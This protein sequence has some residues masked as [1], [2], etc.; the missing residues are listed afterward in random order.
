MM[1]VTAEGLALIKTFEGLRLQAYLDSANIPTLGYG[2][3]RYPTGQ[4]VKLGD[5]C[6]EQ[7]AEAYLRHDLRATEDAVDAMTTDDLSPHQF[8]ALVSLTY[9]IGSHH[10][11]HS[12][13]RQL[14]NA[15]P[16]S[17]AIRDQFLRWVYAGGKVVRGLRE[18]RKREAEHYFS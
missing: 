16:D 13:L 8:D 1:R 11:R 18:R 15:M 17:P 7:Q 2:T 5:T 3:I 6:T 9:N 4:R 14:V 12:T 10:F